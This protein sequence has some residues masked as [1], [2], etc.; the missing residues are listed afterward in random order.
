MWAATEKFLRFL[1]QPP[2]ELIPSGK[3][4]TDI[5]SIPVSERFYPAGT[6]IAEEGRPGRPHLFISS[7]WA[8]SYKSMSNG[9]RLVVDFSQ[10]G[11]LIS[12]SQI[13]DRSVRSTTDATLFEIEAQNHRPLS[14]YSPYLA[15][16]MM[17]LMTRN[18]SIATEHLANVARRRPLE[19]T[20]FLFLETSYRLQQAGDGS[21]DR[22]DF[23]FTQGDLAD[24]LGLTA[25]HTNRVLRD[26]RE[27]GLLSFRNWTVE[28]LDRRNLLE[29]TLFDPGYLDLGEDFVG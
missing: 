6:T 28:L 11:D 1:Q 9:Q 22:Y 16:A 19:R 23:P 24:A 20:A 8:L 2:L 4:I 5:R 21:G 26:L 25:I 14:A 17:R 13:A 10:R 29:M 12:S 7:G 27:Q 3:D 15:H 18:H